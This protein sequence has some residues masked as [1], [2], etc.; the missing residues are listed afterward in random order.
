MLQYKFMFVLY[1]KSYWHIALGVKIRNAYI[2]V[3]KI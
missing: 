2:I 1:S 3:S